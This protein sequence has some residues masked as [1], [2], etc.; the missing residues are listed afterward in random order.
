MSLAR[1]GQLA[2]LKNRRQVTFVV[3]ELAGG[4]L[5]SELFVKFYRLCQAF[6]GSLQSGNL[7]FAASMTVLIEICGHIQIAIKPK[8]DCTLVEH[9]FI[10]ENRC[11]RRVGFA[12]LVEFLPEFRDPLVLIA[13]IVDPRWFGYYP[14]AGLYCPLFVHCSTSQFPRFVH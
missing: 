10:S 13:N 7:S 8:L 3:L 6:D 4:R 11:D 1:V 2:T 5:I 14:G 9:P 12:D